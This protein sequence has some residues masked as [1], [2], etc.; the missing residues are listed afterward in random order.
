MLPK[1][2]CYHFK[3]PLKMTEKDE[4][5]FQEAIMSAILVTRHMPIKISESGITVI[6]QV[7]IEDRLISI[8]I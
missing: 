4:Q 3:K 5:H 8:V 1:D 7:V 2:D 6:S